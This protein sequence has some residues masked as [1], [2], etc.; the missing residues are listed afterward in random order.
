M[1]SEHRMASYELGEGYCR[2]TC[3]CG[4]PSTAKTGPDAE[5]YLRSHLA[6]AAN[7]RVAK[8]RVAA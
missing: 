4:N 1:K 7:Q 3:S 5:R 6:A 8:E 2:V